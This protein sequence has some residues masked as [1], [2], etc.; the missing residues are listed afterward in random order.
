VRETAELLALELHPGAGESAAAVTSATAAAHEHG[1]AAS[2]VAAASAT[3][4]EDRRTSAAPGATAVAMAS[5]PG[6]CGWASTAV[7]TTAPTAVRSA[8]TTTAAATTVAAM[9]IRICRGCDRQRGDAG[10][11]KH[12]GQH[13]KSPSERDKRSVRCTVPTAKRMELSA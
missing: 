11:E 13:E 2:T 6:E 12:P 8:S 7:G 3:A 5:A 10:G 9:R 1:T 4:H